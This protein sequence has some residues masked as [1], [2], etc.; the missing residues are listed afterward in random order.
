MKKLFVVSLII[1]L[2]TGLILT[3][4][5]GPTAAPAPP[6]V[7]GKYGGIFKMAFFM[8]PSRFGVPLNIRHADRLYADFSLQRLL[9]CGEEQGIYEPVL[10]TSWELA[11]D[12]S[13]YTFKLRKGVKF[14][15]GTDF[16]AQAVKW[17][18]D[19]VC[20]SE[21]SVLDKVTSIDVI[22][23]YTVRLNLFAWDNL[24]LDELII[25]DEC[26]II[27][28]TSYEKNGEEWAN[29]NPVGTGPW[30]FKELIRNQ[31]VTYER[32]NDYWEEGLPYLDGVEVCLFADPMTAAAS[33]RAGEVHSLYGVDPG[34]AIELRATGKYNFPSKPGGRVV[35]VMNSTSPDSVWSDKQMREAFEYAVDKEAICEALGHGLVD[36]IYDI[37]PDVLGSPDT[38]PRKYDPEKARQLIAEAGHPGG[39]QVKLTYE[40]EIQPVQRDL[41]LAMQEDLAAVGIQLEMNP[42]AR[43]ALHQMSFEPAPGNDLRVENQRPSGS[44]LGAAKET[45]TSD[46]VYFPGLKRPE[47]FDDL[48]QQAFV[49]RDREKLIALLEKAEELAYGDTMF[50]PLWTDKHI[51]VVDPVVKDYI[52]FVGGTPD[53]RLQYAW[54]GVK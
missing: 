8:P 4:C 20:A 16:N 30:K 6:P 3:S 39:I 40:A 41:L 29:T 11:P 46:S 22:D 14:H 43:A 35:I 50:I 44:A 52:F 13:S 19:K 47:G 5:A 2:V 42:V 15:D 53:M 9:G 51:A 31:V 45:L 26:F 25:R 10:A 1:I 54:L 38:V 12:E 49:E 21:R 28:P 32:F 24:I 37:I 48:L 36:S 23:D 34:S 17:N 7:P 27:S 18:F 33:F